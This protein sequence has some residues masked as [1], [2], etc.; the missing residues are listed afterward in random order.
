MKR[1]FPKYDIRTHSLLFS[2]EDPPPPAGVTPTFP[3]PTPTDRPQQP[4]PPAGPTP[5]HTAQQPAPGDA[6]SAFSSTTSTDVTTTIHTSVHTVSQTVST[7]VPT[8]LSSALGFNAPASVETTQADGSGHGAVVLH[9]LQPVAHAGLE[10]SVQLGIEPNT[11]NLPTYQGMT[12]VCTTQPGIPADTQGNEA[13]PGIEPPTQMHLPGPS[14]EPSVVVVTIQSADQD[15]HPELPAQPVLEPST[16][17]QQQQQQ[18]QQQDGDSAL[19]CEDCGKLATSKK[20]LYRCVH[21]VL[22]GTGI[23]NRRAASAACVSAV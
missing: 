9:M 13:Q 1:Y 14:N 10:Q 3:P 8:V 11:R 16:S 18:Q 5:A 19:R 15:V 2:P 23:S 7:L 21:R 17:G 20:G 6:V 12:E 22:C 4:P